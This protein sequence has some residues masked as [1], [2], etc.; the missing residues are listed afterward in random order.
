LAWA[1]ASRRSPRS[2][3][4][5]HFITGGA[6]G[7]AVEPRGPRG[8]REGQR[9]LRGAAVARWQLTGRQMAAALVR[10]GVQHLRA[11]AAG[12]RR[13]LRRL[14]ALRSPRRPAPSRRGGPG[15]G[16][17]PGP[18]LHRAP[19]AAAGRCRAR[20]PR[21]G[22]GVVRRHGGAGAHDRDRPGRHRAPAA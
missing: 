9:P 18:I 13:Q 10:R 11:D 20:R 4:D 19:R 22:P 2:H 5:V 14:P 1:R 15:S 7:V 3:D 17:P 8:A 21:R 12:V 16:R 6:A